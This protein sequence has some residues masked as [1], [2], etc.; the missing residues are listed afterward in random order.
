M[1]D[2][3]KLLRTNKLTISVILV[4]LLLLLIPFAYSKLFTSKES[5]SQIETAFFL[6]ESNYYTEAIKLTDLDPEHGSYSYKFKISNNDGTKR[7][8]TKMTY[9]LKIVTTTN[10]PLQYKIYMNNIE[11]NIIINDTIAQDEE[12]GAYF[13]TL[14]TEL[15][16]FGYEQNEENNYEL[17]ITFQNDENS[18]VY[19]DT[20]EALFIEIDAKQVTE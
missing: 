17:I 20:V 10:L 13:R 4:F 5:I 15:I 19:Q 9:T 6:L 11:E 8:E 12:N 2:K 18:Y 16:I 14:E 7:L 3:E 1:F